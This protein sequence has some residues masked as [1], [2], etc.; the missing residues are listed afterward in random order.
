MIRRASRADFTDLQEIERA[1]G[2]A[3]AAVGMTSVAE[4]EPFTDAELDAF[5]TAGNAWVSDEDGRVAAYAVVMWV[6]GLLHIEQVSVHPDFAGRGLGARLI[7]HLAST[8]DTPALTLTTFTD[9]PWNAPYYERLGFRRLTAGEETPGLR[10]L[11]AA[12]A[13]HGLDH[14]PRTCMRRDRR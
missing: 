5:T 7:D 12:E 10:E 14:W 13:A 9:V 6:D 1:A 4:D 2:R 3:F 11:R 8:Y